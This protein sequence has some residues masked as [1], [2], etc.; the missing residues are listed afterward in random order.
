[1]IHVMYTW[2]GLGCVGNGTMYT[3]LLRMDG[4][5]P[6]FVWLL[7]VVSPGPTSCDPGPEPQ[8]EEKSRYLWPVQP[9]ASGI[10]KEVCLRSQ[11]SVWTEPDPIS[12]VWTDGPC[13]RKPSN[14]PGIMGL[15]KS[16]ML[17]SLAEVWIHR[18]SQARRVSP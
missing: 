5:F 17:M 8:S 4:C 13:N 6:V 2:L 14:Y 3:C 10:Q 15:K 7:L 11:V 18:A 16:F 1:M 9:L 12:N